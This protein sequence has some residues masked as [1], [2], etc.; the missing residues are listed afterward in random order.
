[1][2]M[3][4]PTAGVLTGKTM[5]Q[6]SPIAAYRESPRRITLRKW[7]KPQRTWPMQASSETFVGIPSST[8]V[9]LFGTKVFSMYFD[10]CGC[11]PKEKDVWR[12]RN[13]A[14]GFEPIPHLPI[15]RLGTS[16]DFH[17]T[18]QMLAKSGAKQLLVVGGNDLPERL[19]RNELRYRPEA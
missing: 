8:L 11:F 16:E 12:L 10:F 7:Q 17:S 2:N 13:F 1:M 19:E 9:P 18:L 5:C 6:E 4:K 14:A 3:V 15:S